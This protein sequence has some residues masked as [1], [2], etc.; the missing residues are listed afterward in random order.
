MNEIKYTVK[1]ELWSPRDNV[2]YNYLDSRFSSGK[3][4]SRFLC[5]SYRVLNG[6]HRL[7]SDVTVIVRHKH[8]LHRFVSGER[9]PAKVKL[10]V[11]KQTTATML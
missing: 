6:R 4:T 2:K 9:I 10:A 7:T 5:V 3:R 1:R 11:I 8:K